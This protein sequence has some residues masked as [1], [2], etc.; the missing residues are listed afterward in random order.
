MRKVLIAL[1]GAASALAVATPA[2]AQYY[3]GPPPPYG[4]PYGN[5]YGYNNYGHVR[6][7]QVRLNNL[8]RQ[9]QRL[10]R[11]DRVSEREAR[12]LR[13]EARDLE[14]RLAYAS[15]GGLSPREFAS[16]EYRLQRLEQHI[17]R[18]ANDGN[19]WRNDRRD[20]RW[21]DRDRD[22]RNDRWEDDRGYRHD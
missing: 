6:A 9:I 18:E 22:G 17:W 16:I 1:A 13:E 7:L 19:R 14:R 15:R 2:A 21:I 20:G 4:A 8:E 12:R 10:D 11:R 5:A 3:P